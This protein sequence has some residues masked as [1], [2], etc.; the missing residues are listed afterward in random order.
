MFHHYHTTDS[1]WLSNNATLMISHVGDDVA[2]STRRWITFDSSAFAGTF[3][4]APVLCF[5]HVFTLS[6]NTS[7]DPGLVL[8][9]CWRGL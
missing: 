8:I 4:Q 9:V 3:I 7:P 5:L 2:L 6:V 1:T